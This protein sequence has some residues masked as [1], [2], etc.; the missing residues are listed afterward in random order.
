MECNDILRNKKIYSDETIDGLRR[1]NSNLNREN[2]Q[3]I[4]RNHELEK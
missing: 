2:Q 4:E 3:F 1:N